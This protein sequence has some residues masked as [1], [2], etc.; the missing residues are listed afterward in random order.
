MSTPQLEN[1]YTKI[2]TEIMEALIKYRIPGEQMQCL[3]FII[4]KTYGWHKKEDEISLSQFMEATGLIKP[5]VCRAIN[6]LK[7]KNVIFV[8]KKAN[9]T[10]PTYSFNKKH[11]EWKALAKKII[12]SKKDNQRYQKSQSSLAKKIIPTLYTKDT[13]KD[14]KIYSVIINYLNEK[15]DKNFRSTTKETKAHINA[16]LRE[17]FTEKDFKKVIDI[18]CS[19]WKSDPK[20]YEYLRPKTLFGNNFEAYLQDN[21]NIKDNNEPY[22]LFK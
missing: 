16:R 15:A 17:G 11:T 19:K 3:L 20:M 9:R 13:T 7:L 22:R 10:H 18:K 12:V 21:P 5:S 6:N 1:G 4:R 14:K 2:A 8:S